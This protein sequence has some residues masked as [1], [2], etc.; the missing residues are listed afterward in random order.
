[1]NPASALTLPP[2]M[3]TPKETRDLPRAHGLSNH[4]SGVDPTAPAMPTPLPTTHPEATGTL[5]PTLPLLDTSAHPSVENAAGL[6]LPVLAATD[7]NRWFWWLSTAGVLAAGIV[8]ASRD[9]A[10]LQPGGSR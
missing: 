3:T 4:K 8:L 10:G 2:A 5:V 7:P 1:M 9:V 6:P